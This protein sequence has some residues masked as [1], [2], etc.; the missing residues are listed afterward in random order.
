MRRIPADAA[1]A[2]QTPIRASGGTGP[3][4]GPAKNSTLARV[5]TSE[6]ASG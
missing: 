2:Y 6:N 5:A 3:R 1:T 4:S